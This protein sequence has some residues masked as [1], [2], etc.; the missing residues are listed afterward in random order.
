MKDENTY[1]TS[2]AIVEPD[3]GKRYRKYFYKRKLAHRIVVD[4]QKAKVLAAYVLIEKDLRCATIWLDQIIT[5]LQD[6]PLF[7]DP[8]GTVVSPGGHKYILAKGFFVAAITFYGK[9]YSN[10]EGRRVKLERANLP[11]SFSSV[12]D[13]VIEFRNNFAAHSG[14]QKIEDAVVILALDSKR[15]AAPYFSKELYQPD[16]VSMD[17]L[18]GMLELFGHV[19]EFVDRKVEILSDKVYEED[20][21]PKGSDYWYGKT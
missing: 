16:I 6:E 12:H 10:C 2:N 20:V 4:T 14:A 18:E 11:E 13:S 8:K 17:D 19:K 15:K 9:C 5:L 1:W 7:V 3:T 21:L